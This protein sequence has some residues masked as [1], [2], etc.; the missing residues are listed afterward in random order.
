[1]P[2]QA[3][4]VGIATLLAARSLMLLVTGA[5]KADILHRALRGPQGPEVPASFLR[6]HAGLVVVADRAAVARL[7]RRAFGSTAGQLHPCDEAHGRLEGRLP[8]TPP[9][10]RAQDGG[11]SPSRSPP[12]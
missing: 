9:H 11:Q 5:G 4:I 3:L 12:R 10:S 1:V 8:W 6:D 2:T 7:W